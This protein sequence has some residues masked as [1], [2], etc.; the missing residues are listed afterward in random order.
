MIG[1]IVGSY[2]IIEKIGEGGMGAVFKGV[3]LM[4]EREVAVKMLRPEL[5]RQPELVERFRSEAVT[6]AK[7]LHPNIATL[8]SFLR[9]GDDFFMIMEYVAG[10]SLEDVIRSSGAMPPA[11]AVLMFCQALDGI[12]YAHRQ[13]I[14]HRDLKPANLM[15]TSDGSIKVMDFGIARVLG[16]AR[17]TRAGH[18]VGTIEYMSP[19][20]IH[21]EETDIRSDL[22][23]LGIVLY[24]MLTGRLPFCSTSEYELLKMHVEV[25]VP[26]PR[27]LAA[28]ISEGLEAVLLRALEK[29][30]ENR[31]ASAAQLRAALT[32]RLSEAEAPLPAQA[33]A[34]RVATASGGH[35]AATRIAF[36]PP[37]AVVA[38]APS[39]R[40][41]PGRWLLVA[42]VAAVLVV[43]VAVAG[44]VYMRR[45]SPQPAAVEATRP[46]APPP[47]ATGPGQMVT[48]PPV[49]PGA[50][51]SAPGQTIEVAPAAA[52]GLI[53][54]KAA[55]L[56]QQPTAA[57]EE[58]EKRR[59]ATLKALGA[60][61]SADENARRRARALKAL[62]SK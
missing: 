4:L 40:S 11:A 44:I 5:A 17:V 62:E 48:A 15:L 38:A 32:E 59:A 41:R 9:Q 1:R 30:P 34:T 16:A 46:A 12:E 10:R 19:E 42:L 18:L 45:V 14:L 51:A 47:A 28:G 39:V 25:P 8:Y 21:G 24:E 52:Q 2:K 7:L 27:S 56:R 55:T 37:P 13:G 29:K 54:G 50:A 53:D 43:L 20:R 60:T 36:A 33:K 49:A 58:R 35:V 31:F 57:R 6:L 3:D 23:S 26:P 61:P 22:Y